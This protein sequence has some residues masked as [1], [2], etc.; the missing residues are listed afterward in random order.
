[1]FQVNAPST[2]FKLLAPATTASNIV[3]LGA[4]CLVPNTKEVSTNVIGLCLLY[5]T[6]AME[7]TQTYQTPPTNGKPPANTIVA[8]NYKGHVTAVQDKGQ[9][10]DQSSPATRN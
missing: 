6:V 9:R 3:D 10:S 7:G 4:P 5:E 1:M 8:R 2:V